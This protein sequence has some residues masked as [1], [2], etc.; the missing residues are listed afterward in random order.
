MIED[1]TLGRKIFVIL[2]VAFM[3][4]FTMLCLIPLINIL[5]LSFSGSSA[6]GSGIV[7]LLPVDFTLKAYEFVM[8]NGH[9]WNS[10]RVSFERVAIGLPAELFLTVITA[11]PLSRGKREFGFRTFYVWFLFL[12]VLF[13]GG[14]ISTYM[15][16]KYTGIM[17]S[18]AALILPG[19]VNVFNII[20]MINFFRDL[21]K[22]MEEAAFIDGAG[23][24][25]LLRH[26]LIPVSLPSIATITV[27]I[28]VKH[29]NSW[30]DG[31]IYMNG[32][33][34]YPLQT[35]LQSLVIQRDTNLMMTK[36][37]AE[38]L[39]LISEK[40]TKSAQVFLATLPIFAVYPFLQRYFITGLV[41]GSIKG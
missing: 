33:S 9:F 22:E 7:K 31:M 16:V 23:H 39:A 1:S 30:F 29:W 32:V 13:S 38:L 35:Y 28:L 27:F 37:E 5:A 15:V 20:L 26:V 25:T 18:M 10:F 2:N 8:D 36:E 40:T 14:I 11:Y 24:L 6:A 3:L 34:K 4:L 21:P 41:L 12:S 19:V 17:N